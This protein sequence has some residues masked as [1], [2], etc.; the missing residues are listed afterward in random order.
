LYQE[1][2]ARLWRELGLELVNAG[3]SNQDAAVEYFGGMQRCLTVAG[4]LGPVRGPG[5][6]EPGE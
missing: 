5:A 6:C 1:Q 2:A 3:K 4:L